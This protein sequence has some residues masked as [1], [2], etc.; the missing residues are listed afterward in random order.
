ME[1]RLGNIR[2]GILADKVFFDSV[3]TDGNFIWWEDKVEI[4]VS[5]VFQ[6]AQ[7]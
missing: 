5:E 3:T 6:L 4:S 1:S 7:K 2:V